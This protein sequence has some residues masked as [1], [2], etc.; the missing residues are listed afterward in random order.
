MKAAMSD[1]NALDHTSLE[2]SSPY[3][4]RVN[5]GANLPETDVRTAL[6]TGDMGFLHSFTTGSAVDGPGIRVVAWT[7]GC[8]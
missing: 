3:E 5:L 4:F 2:A 6:A 7:A 8:M 1:K